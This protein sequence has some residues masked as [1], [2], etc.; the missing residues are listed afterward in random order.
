M[1]RTP[2]F[3]MVPL[4]AVAKKVGHVIDIGTGVILLFGSFIAL[5]SSLVIFS[6]I[7]NSV[8]HDKK[9]N[10]L[11][12]S[13]GLIKIDCIKVIGIEW[14]ITAVIVNTG[15]VLASLLALTLVYQVHFSID[16]KTNFVTILTLLTENILVLTI[17]GLTLSYAS[18]QVST[19]DFLNQPAT[20]NH[21]IST[22]SIAQLSAMHSQV[23]KHL[24]MSKEVK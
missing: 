24:L 21:P 19:L 9:R 2:L 20:S 16:Y 4:K 5:M 13:F 11:I 22:F 17:L 1:A 10:G 15:V 14:I 23:K 7:S 12:L 6:A 18:L 8:D 3:K